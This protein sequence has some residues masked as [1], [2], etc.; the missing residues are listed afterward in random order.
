[1][2]PQPSDA[3]VLYLKENDEKQRLMYWRGQKEWRKTGTWLNN[4]FILNGKDIWWL[5]LCTQNTGN[6]IQIIKKWDENYD[7]RYF[8]NQ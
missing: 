7:G 2:L 6:L 4:F 3:A 8:K 5:S 1:M